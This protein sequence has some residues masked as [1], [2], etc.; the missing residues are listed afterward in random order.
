MKKVKVNVK[1]LKPGVIPPKVSLPFFDKM[2]ITCDVPAD[3]RESVVNNLL[4]CKSSVYGP[5]G[6]Y[7][8]ARY[9]SVEP[10]DG[11]GAEWDKSGDHRMLVQCDPKPGYKHLR[12]L[13]CEW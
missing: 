4:N 13:R 1:L 2:S 8:H 10:P 6:A 9:L 3:Q 11:K 12:F 7:H 5:K